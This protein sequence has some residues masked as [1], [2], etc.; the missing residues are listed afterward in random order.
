MIYGEALQFS[1][2][3]QSAGFLKCTA[4]FPYTV[5]HSTEQFRAPKG[6][7]RTIPYDVLVPVVSADD[8]ACRVTTGLPLPSGE[9]NGVKTPRLTPLVR[10]GFEHI[11]TC[12]SNTI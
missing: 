5:C 12:T 11:N 9:A 1:N 8:P 10:I 4:C 7:G 6:F 2:D 3:R